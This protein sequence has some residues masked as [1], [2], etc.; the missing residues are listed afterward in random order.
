MSHFGRPSLGGPR[1]AGGLSSKAASSKEV[2]CF[3][4]LK[5]EDIIEVLRDMGVVVVEDDINK[6]KSEQ[7][8]Q[9]CELFVMD[10]LG[11]S[12][13][14]MYAPQAD[15]ANVLGEHAALHDESVPVIH[16]LRNV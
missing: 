2:F 10:I 6:P 12:K 4:V 7:F 9:V 11:L 3:P 5:V 13:E 1:A 14:D 16:F 15:F 8:R